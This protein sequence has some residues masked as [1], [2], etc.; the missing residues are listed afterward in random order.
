MPLASS[1]KL[2]NEITNDV[3]QI[4]IVS[5]LPPFAA[6]QARSLCK[7][8][9]QRHPGLKIIL[10]L[11]NLESVVKGEERL[12]SGGAD[13]IATSLQQVISLLAENNRTIGSSNRAQDQIAAPQYII[14]TRL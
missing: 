9:R 14:A 13:M 8:L 10:G 7:R 12:G 11:W 1:A 3:P 2:L 4:V 6:G 5:A